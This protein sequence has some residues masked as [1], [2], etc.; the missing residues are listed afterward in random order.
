MYN[1][2]PDNYTCPICLGVEGVE[3]KDTLLQ[4]QDLVYRDDLVSVFVNSFFIGKNPGHVIVVP[5]QHFENLYDLPEQYA[6]RVIEISQ[7]MAVA[8]KKAYGCDGVMIGQNNEPA[9]GQH[10]FHYHMHIFP[11]Y[12][13]DEIHKYMGSKRLAPPEERLTYVKKLRRVL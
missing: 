10:A 5:N 8:I 13:N 12:E 11:R 6:H 3:S 4:Q 9:S 1:H 2:A 7:K